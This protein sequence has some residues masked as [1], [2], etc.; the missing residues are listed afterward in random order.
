MNRPRHTESAGFRVSEVC[1]LQV[2]H[3]DF[4]RR[5]FHVES[6]KKREKG[7][8]RTVPMTDR[9]FSHLADWWEKLPDRKDPEAYLFPA[10]HGSF[11]AH[12]NR[13]QVW[14]R[15]KK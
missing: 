11:K 6:L 7:V 13:K 15:V 12:M 2:K 10:A 14:R 1:K 4:Y 8:F 5:E 3:F 9:L